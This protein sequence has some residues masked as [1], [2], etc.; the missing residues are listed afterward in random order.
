MLIK[1][2]KE[3]LRDVKTKNTKENFDNK[4]TNKRISEAIAMNMEMENQILM[5]VKELEKMGHVLDAKF[6]VEKL[7]KKSVAA[8]QQLEV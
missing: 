3:K 5:L 2:L 4:R 1:D 8:R 6:G 7:L